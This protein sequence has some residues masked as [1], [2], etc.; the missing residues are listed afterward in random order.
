MSFLRSISLKTHTVAA[1]CDLLLTVANPSSSLE[2]IIIEILIWYGPDSDDDEDNDEESCDCVPSLLLK[3]LAAVMERRE[4]C[5]IKVLEIRIPS[6]L[7]DEALDLV[8]SHFESWKKRDA[9]KLG[10]SLE[11]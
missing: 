8:G 9:L 2:S 3:R 10:F 4:L 5:G 1:I 11:N 7:G 6:N